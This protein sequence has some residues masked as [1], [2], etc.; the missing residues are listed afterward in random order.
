[1]R[2]SYTTKKGASKPATAQQPAHD[3]PSAGP[4]VL[5]SPSATHK[6]PEK[7]EVIYFFKEFSS[8]SLNFSIIG[9]RDYT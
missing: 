1:M 7:F 5:P 9:A 3:L 8:V 2:R 6:R 4:I